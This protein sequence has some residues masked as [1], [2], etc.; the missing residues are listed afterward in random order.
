MVQTYLPHFGCCVNIPLDTQKHRAVVSQVNALFLSATA[1]DVSG[2]LDG[3]NKSHSVVVY[4]I[5]ISIG[6]WS[7]GHSYCD[8]RPLEYLCRLE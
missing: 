7:I 3:I 4:W 2:L 8:G 5:W 1:P 6:V